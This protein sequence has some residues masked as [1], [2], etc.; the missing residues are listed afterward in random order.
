[1]G[2]YDVIVSH[3]T[4]FLLGLST[5]LSP[6]SGPLLFSVFP[7]IV[8]KGSKKGSYLTCVFS[9]FVIMFGVGLI[10]VFMGYVIELIYLVKYP[11]AAGLLILGALML[12]G[13]Q[14]MTSFMRGPISGKGLSTLCISY[15]LFFQSM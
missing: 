9:V 7:L 13:L 6:C 8:S 4:I 12:L 1:M 2:L 10:S 14:P 3:I 15:A 11:I 5:S